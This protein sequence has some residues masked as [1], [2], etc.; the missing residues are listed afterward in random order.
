MRV[1]P[2]AM[3]ISGA[4]GT[5]KGISTAVDVFRDR[6]CLIIIKFDNM[7]IKYDIFIK[8]CDNIYHNG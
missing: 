2:S 1:T 8:K 4:A 3:R 6:A 5:G 7:R